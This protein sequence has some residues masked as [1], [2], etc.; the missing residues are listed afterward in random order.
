[1]GVSRAQLHCYTAC[2]SCDVELLMYYALWL[3][4]IILRINSSRYR[5]KH[6]YESQARKT[7][8]STCQ[9][10]VIDCR[11][12]WLS[13]GDELN[14]RNRSTEQ[15]AHKTMCPIIEANTSSNWLSTSLVRL[16]GR[17]NL[18]QFTSSE[19]TPHNEWRLQHRLNCCRVYACWCYENLVIT[20]QT[21][22][23][24]QVRHGLINQLIFVPIR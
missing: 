23:D 13:Q 16:F 21:A 5:M 17:N 20:N 22:R 11:V 1:M 14:R 7:F 8:R 15:L 6:R 12:T 2:M 4:L 18:E 19:N 9:V 24:R 3:T 10:G